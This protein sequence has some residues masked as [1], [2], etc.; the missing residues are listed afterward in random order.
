MILL[1]PFFS[2]V[3]NLIKKPIS[4]FLLGFLTVGL[5]FFLTELLIFYML[6]PRSLTGLLFGLLWSFL[7]SGLVLFLPR[8]AGRIVYGLLYFP[9]L[10]WGLAQIGYHQFFGNLMWLSTTTLAGEGTDY[11]G[12]ILSGFPF[13]WWFALIALLGIGVAVIWFFP[14]SP[15]KIL[16]R[17]PY[18]AC[19]VLFVVG[20]FVLPEVIF[21][22]ERDAH[23]PVTS[24]QAIY[25]TMNSAKEVYDITGLYQLLARDIW[26]NK[27]Y[28]L[29]PGQP[30]ATPQQLSVTEAFFA[31]RGPTG[32]NKM[33]GAFAGKNVVLVMME[34]MDDWMIT[35]ADTPTLSKL[36]T[37]GVNFTN[38]Y[39]PGYGSARTL[40]SEFCMNTGLYLPTTGSEVFDYVNNCFD[41]SFAMQLATKGYDARV[42]HYNADSFYSRDELEPAMGYMEY[43]SYM[44]YTEDKEQL[45]NE[46]F[47]FDREEVRS[48]F[49]REGQTFNTI[50]TRAAHLGYTYNEITGYFALKKYPHYKGLYASE[51]EICARVK[52]KIVDDMFARLLQ[53][54]EKEGL[55]ENTVIIGMT[56]HYTYGY[57]NIEELYSHSGVDSDLLLEKVPCFIWSA[58][59]PSAQVDKTLS[60]ADFLPTMLNLLGINSPYNYLGQDAFAVNYP[61]YAL[62]PDGSWITDG[63]AW[64]DGQILMNKKGREVSQTEIDEMAKLS[65]EFRT[66]SNLLLTSN[67]YENAPD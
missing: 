35:D 1:N 32:P 65:R 62:F 67:Y 59:G 17:L 43:V 29:I 54:L 28:P 66:I 56:D 4:R 36:M 13:I 10:L 58:D 8:L 11:L 9:L 27:L 20:L 5:S 34:S 25:E 38:F 31:Q 39:A 49:F 26:V 16:R 53:E 51:E 46:Q 44:D 12:D 3:Q 6:G 30:S 23:D 2:K 42:F 14:H 61:G 40:N 48:I 41:Q 57:K 45:C 37:E 60:T 33:T 7:L 64:Q 50:I 18:L 24:R 19:S 55:L 21:L 52:A 15:A 63:V 22:S 47:M